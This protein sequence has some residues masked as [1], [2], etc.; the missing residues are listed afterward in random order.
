MIATDTLSR[1]LDHGCATWIDVTGTTYD[2]P[3][4][5]P[6]NGFYQQRSQSMSWLEAATPYLE[7]GDAIILGRPSTGTGRDAITYWT[8]ATNTTTSSG[9]ALYDRTCPNLPQYRTK[10]YLAWSMSNTEG[11]RRRIGEGHQPL[12]LD[13]QRPP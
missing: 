12:P 6:S 1:N 9:Y 10:P 13:R 8:N 7:T 3:S 4:V 2:L 11:V 5:K